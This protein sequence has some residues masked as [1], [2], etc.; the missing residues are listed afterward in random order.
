MEH[1]GILA[2][3]GHRD[4]LEQDYQLDVDP[5]VEL[6]TDG[7]DFGL[8][9]AYDEA[10]GATA[11]DIPTDAVV[12]TPDSKPGHN[13]GEAHAIA[14]DDDQRETTEIAAED[15]GGEIEVDTEY[16]DEIGYEDDDLVATD[17]NVD[18]GRTEQAVGADAGFSDDLSEGHVESAQSAQSA[19]PVDDTDEDPSVAGRDESW[20][21]DVDFEEHGGD[22]APQYGLGGLDEENTPKEDEGGGLDVDDFHE[23]TVQEQHS[24]DHQVSDHEKAADDLAPSSA[25]VPSIDVLYN[26]EYYTL[27]GNMEDDPDSYFLSGV[28]LLDQPLSR[29]L[30]ALRRVISEEI[31]RTDELVVR[32]D[33]LDLE[34]GERSNEKF[35]CRSFREL[36]DCH[37][38]LSQVPGISAEPVIHLIVRRDAEEQ[39]LELLANAELIKCQS[40]Q[41]EDSEMSDDFENYSPARVPDD[42][43]TK[44]EPFTDDHVAE[45]YDDGEPAPR[46]IAHD[47]GYVFAGDAENENEPQLNSPDGAPAGEQEHDFEAGVD[48]AES[49]TEETGP[50]EGLEDMEAEAKPHEH[51]LGAKEGLEDVDAEG[52]SPEY[53]QLEDR[54]AEEQSLPEQVAEDDAT[55]YQHAEVAFEMTEERIHQPT[56][57]HDGGESTEIMEA[58]GISALNAAAPEHDGTEQE[59]G[60]HEDD[61]IL[62]FDDEAAPTTAREEADDYEE[63]TITYETAEHVVNDTEATHEPP[64]L[65]NA[66]ESTSQ[67]H[68]EQAPATVGGETTSSHSSATIAGDEIDYEEHDDVD[69]SL[70]PADDGALPS[71]PTPGIDN[72]EIDWNDGDEDEQQPAVEDGGVDYEEPQEAAMAPSGLAGKRSRTDEEESLGDETDHKRRRT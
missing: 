43:E 22:G 34:F 69:D 47:L 36:L 19:Q 6:E 26:E 62:A 39:F 49:L 10:E 70:T 50:E 14:A 20:H 66:N 72:D 61:L 55:G 40:Q 68:Q 2:E 28:E 65:E 52:Q 71:A 24:P 21:Q 45:F 29:F 16:Q 8:E 37:T 17:V 44:D 56:E 15:A 31:T 5:A 58:T 38:T 59:T 54:T 12:P 3:S 63:Y 18:L 35:L 51:E 46:N 11:G 7:F 32:F 57:E 64:E 42:E 9:E 25:G 48:A 27:F 23:E 41:S 4:Q 60:A 1:A 30:S 67:N 33:P 13:D 53:E